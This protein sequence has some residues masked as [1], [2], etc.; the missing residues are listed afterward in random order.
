[1][2]NK[3]PPQLDNERYHIFVEADEEIP[4][5]VSRIQKTKHKIIGLVVTRGSGLLQSMVN[6][7]LLKREAERLEKELVLITIDNVAVNLANQLDIKV[8]ENIKTTEPLSEPQ[9]EAPQM[10]EKIKIDKTSPDPLISIHH[11]QDSGEKEVEKKEQKDIQNLPE[12]TDDVSPVNSDKPELRQDQPQSHPNDMPLTVSGFHDKKDIDSAASADVRQFPSERTFTDY[13]NKITN[14]DRQRIS[15]KPKL[16]INKKIIIFSAIAICIFAAGFYFFA[17]AAV[18]TFTVKGED[19]TDNFRVEANISQKTI[20]LEERKIPAHLIQEEKEEKKNFP[21]TGKKNMGEKSRGTVTFYNSW[22]TDVQTL[23]AGAKISN[24]DKEFTLSG[25]TKIAGATLSL[26]EGSIKTNPGVSDGVVEAAIAGENYNLEPTK[27]II[28]GFNSEKQSK[29]YAES[30]RKF[31]GGSTREV[32]VV[33][34]EDIEKAVQQLRGQLEES[35]LNQ[36]IE[37]NPSKTILKDATDFDVLNRQVSVNEN[38]E[39]EKFDLTLKIRSRNIGFEKETFQKSFM[40]I[41]KFELPK[42]K[43]L[44]LTG[45]EEIATEVKEK[46]I[47]K[48]RLVIEGSIKAKIAPRL[49]EMK[50]KKLIYGQK[51]GAAKETLSQQPDIEQVDISVSP[52][53]LSSRIPYFNFAIKTKIEYQ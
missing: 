16:R 37:K 10:R 3:K 8:Y 39:V 50:L 13:A 26:S 36:L 7:K 44:H 34:A 17:P 51:V 18:I 52:E 47:E 23:P 24:G 2:S 32:K 14:P 35:L 48:G 28:V 31:T 43:D 42:D 25:E 20:S 38:D 49:D 12:G 11:F 1:M 9:R 45:G 4:S 22:S 21:A 40:D 53:W 6:L 33:S 30:Q 15:L 19:F 41:L 46:D 27:F 5:I 29:F